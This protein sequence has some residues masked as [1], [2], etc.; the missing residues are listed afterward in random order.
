MSN[1]AT[2]ALKEWKPYIYKNKTRNKKYLLKQ[3]NKDNKIKHKK[4]KEWNY[5]Y[6]T[7]I[8]SDVTNHQKYIIRET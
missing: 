2:H 5:K 3:K 6:C 1:N 4:G 7:Y 8:Y